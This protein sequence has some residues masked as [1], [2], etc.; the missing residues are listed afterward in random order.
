MALIRGEEV[1]QKLGWPIGR[2]DKLARKGKLPHVLLPD[3]SI[4]FQWD[5]ISA[6]I[7]HVAMP[8]AAGGEGLPNE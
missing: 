1:D 6:L 3:E 2:A 7:R 4:R 8:G 5:A